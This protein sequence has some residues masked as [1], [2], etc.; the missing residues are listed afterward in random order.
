M[1][2]K[3]LILITLMMAL[4]IALSITAVCFAEEADPAEE[5]A[6]EAEEVTADNDAWTWIKETWARLK[7]VIGVSL[8]AL[9]GAVVIVV[10]KHITNSGLDTIKKKMD[11]K[12][13]ADATS[14]NFL[15]NIADV[16]L[17]VNIKPIVESQLHEMIE[18][19]TNYFLEALKKQD[20]KQLAE[21][22]A[23]KQLGAYFDCSVAVSDEAKAK[24][25]KAIQDA[26]A[27]YSNIDNKATAKVEVKSEEKEET[28]VTIAENY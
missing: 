15:K 18:T 4:I 13:I 21:L 6:I 17:D 2:K 8:S 27:L 22:L 12:T 11:A 7:E 5:P 9:V 1:K 3:L 26:E 14:E 16:E 25:A 20:K 23:L 24:F 19:I 10:V 28:K